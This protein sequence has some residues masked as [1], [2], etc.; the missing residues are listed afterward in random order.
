VPSAV[1]V[2]LHVEI[3]AFLP[4]RETTLQTATIPQKALESLTGFRLPL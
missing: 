3:P 1:T 2:D 4:H